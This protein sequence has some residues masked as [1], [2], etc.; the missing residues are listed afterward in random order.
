MKIPAC[1]SPLN[2]KISEKIKE[3]PSSEIAEKKHEKPSN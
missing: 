1:L 2:H 3:E